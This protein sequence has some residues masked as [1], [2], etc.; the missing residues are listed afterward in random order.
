MESKDELKE[1]DIKN[2]TCYCFYDIK[3]D[4]DFCSHDNLSDKKSYE[5]YEIVLLY[6]YIYIIMIYKYTFNT[7]SS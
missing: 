3:T 5:T 6:I 7:H 1:I 2:C 4:R